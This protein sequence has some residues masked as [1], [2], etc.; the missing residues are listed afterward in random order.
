MS[1][2]RESDMEGLRHD[3]VIALRVTSPDSHLGAYEVLNMLHTKGMC[4]TLNRPAHNVHDLIERQ[5]VSTENVLFI[6]GI[7]VPIQSS[8]RV[9]EWEYIPN[10]RELNDI[11]S[12]IERVH[13]RL[14]Q[15]DKFLFV[16]A[17]HDL[18]YYHDEATMV[19]FV[20]FLVQRLRVLRLQTFLV[21]DERKLQRNI[22]EKLYSL[23]DKVITV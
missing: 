11:L 16:D 18:L 6:D 15:G 3:S 14:P 5:G 23:V 10:P 22:R 4:L 19:R 2:L 17:F 1:K 7:S 21:I 12:S 20:D 8:V 9:D 13:K